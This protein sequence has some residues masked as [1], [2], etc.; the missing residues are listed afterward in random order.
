MNR[1]KDVFSVKYGEFKD[2]FNRLAKGKT[3]FISS[4]SKNNGVVGYFD[5]PAEYKHVISVPRTGTICYAFYHGYD[6]MINSDCM[7][8]TPKNKLTI[9]EMFYY[10]TLIRNE[11]Y[12][13]NYGRKVTPDRLGETR[14]P[15]EIPDWVHYSAFEEIEGVIA[16][17]TKC[18]LI[19][20]TNDW[21]YFNYSELFLIKKG[22]RITK[23]DMV[24]GTT[25]CIRPTE[26]NNGVVGYIGHEPNH[27]GNTITVSYNGSVGEAF[28]QEIPHFS[29]DDV[30]VLYPK[31]PM[32][33]YIALFLCTII[34]REKYRFNYGR[35]WHLERMNESVMK[36]PVTSTSDPDWQFME[37]YIKTMNFSSKI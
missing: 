29:L 7:V 2:P 16:P 8:L 1:I 14:I 36:L 26:H 6:C 37:R 13:Y 22:Q 11:K 12:R 24:P 33:K 23:R 32:S 19:L 18:N 28:Y 10:V 15:V 17:F 27:E 25:P 35:K 5:V 9:E 20:N 31:F 34:R 21:K 30:N 4:G 3:P